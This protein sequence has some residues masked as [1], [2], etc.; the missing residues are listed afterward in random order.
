[1]GPK[2]KKQEPQ[3]WP[4]TITMLSKTKDSFQTFF[5]IKERIQR[6]KFAIEKYFTD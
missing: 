3:T 2:M 4:A 5:I 6:I 1:M